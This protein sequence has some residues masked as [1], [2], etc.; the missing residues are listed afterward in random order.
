LTR[1]QAILSALVVQCCRDQRQAA[2]TDMPVDG[3]MLTQDELPPAEP[4]DV[5]I[6]DDDQLL[7][8][9]RVASVLEGVI[10]V[11]VC[12]LYI[13]RDVRHVQHHASFSNVCC[14][15]RCRS[16]AVCSARGLCC[17]SKT[18]RHWAG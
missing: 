15:G 13:M 11:Q 7:P 3:S 5:T 6:S 17:V 10:I 16:L 14:I 12:V 1:L 18:A 8:A 9:G 2:A 4:L